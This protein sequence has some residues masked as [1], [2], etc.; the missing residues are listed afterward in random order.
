MS[1]TPRTVDE[2]TQPL[3]P[4]SRW[5]TAVLD[6][7]RRRPLGAIGAGIVV[8]M[9]IT[10]ATA[11]MLAP[12]DPLETDYAA[13]L[14]APDARHWLGTDAF[15]RDVFS[16]IMYGSRTALMV[17]LG[18]SFLGA[19]IGSI[20]GVSSAYFGGRVDL[21]VQRVMDV[22]F[23]FPVIILALAVVAILGT[24]AGNVILAIA[25]PMIPRCARVVRASALA[26]REMPYVDAAR[27]SGFRDS[28][29]ILRHMLPNVMAPI[30]ILATAFLGEAILLE[31]S[32]SFLGLGVQEPT[33]AWGLMLRGAAVEFAET[34]PW[35]A[36]FP[37]L[38]ISLA[39]FG[40][41]LF[42]DSLRDALDPRLRTQ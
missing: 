12:F 7:V 24:G 40:F 29:I 5:T 30:L 35:M 25:V 33:A 9:V 39:V 17:G 1:V 18:A 11:G 22:F 27:A 38:A 3:A 32:L 19:T 34:A 6:F 14:A 16:R 15:G 37:G 8:L 26:V 13:M 4:R 42:G 31:A 10:A 41:N 20:I 36:I 21:V 28:R 23:A 2:L